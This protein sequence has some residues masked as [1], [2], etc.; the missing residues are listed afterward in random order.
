MDGNHRFDRVFLELAY[1]GRLIRPGGVVF[2]DDYQP[3]GVARVA[4][5]FIMNLGWKIEG[6]SGV[7]QVPPVWAVLRTSRAQDG[8][9]FDYFAEF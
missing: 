7:C 3:P 2:L 6:V 4:S 8:R 5:F 1:L 9:N